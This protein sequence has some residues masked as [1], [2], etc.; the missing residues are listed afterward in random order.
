MPHTFFC[1][2]RIS[3]VGCTK[4]I[5][6]MKKLHCFFIVCSLV[7]VQS[8]FAQRNNTRL[9]EEIV[10]FEHTEAFSL[11]SGH[12]MMVTPLVA[13]VEV[14][15]KGNDGKTFEH[16]TFTGSARRDKP[17]GLAGNEYLVSKYVEGDHFSIRTELLK[18]QVIYDFCRETGADLI[19]LPQF[20]IYHKVK[21]VQ[22]IDAK[23]NT[24]DVDQPV[25]YNGKYVMV[26]EAVGFPAR[27]S[28][29]RQGTQNDKWI[30]ELYRMGQ[31][32]NNDGAIQVVEQDV[33]TV[34][35]N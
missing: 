29:F 13:S 27:Y 18:A 34:R 15:S 24:I 20:N 32:N 21:T 33:R 16:R 17:A 9:V 11:E 25:E 8:A 6:Q 1:C 7:F 3:E 26:V 19:V 28:G 12:E 2:F 23:G 5:V 4:R 14:L 31:I 35:T 30:K 10:T 22:A